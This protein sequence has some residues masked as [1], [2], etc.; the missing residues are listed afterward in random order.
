MNQP[1]SPIADGY[2]WAK[3]VCVDR[4]QPVYLASPSVSVIG[5]DAHDARLT[6]RDVATFGPRIEEPNTPPAAAQT[7][8]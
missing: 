4:W 2:Y 8:R 3:L 1:A 6:V 5:H 7:D